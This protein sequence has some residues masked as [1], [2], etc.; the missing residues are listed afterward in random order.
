[1]SR[2]RALLNVQLNKVRDVRRTRR[3]CGD[4]GFRRG[5]CVA[6]RSCSSL[7]EVQ[8][9]IV[10]DIQQ[11]CRLEGARHGPAAKAADAEAGRLLRREHHD[12]DCSLWLKALHT[13]PLFSL[14]WTSNTNK[15]IAA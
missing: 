2:G 8:P 13:V 3:G 14:I 11:R 1:M 5:L 7:H 6:A 12:L 10:E 15:H 4:G 9:L